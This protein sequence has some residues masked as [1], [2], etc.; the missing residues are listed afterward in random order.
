MN[1]ST[2]T[3]DPR[4]ARIHYDDY[5]KRCRL[6]REQRKKQAI[7]SE[8]HD[9][10]TGRVK[11][12]QLER[13]D[14]ELMKAYRALYRGQQILDMPKTI[15]KGGLNERKLPHLAICRADKV[16]CFFETWNNVIYMHH[17]R[18]RTWREH[19]LGCFKFRGG[20]F[21]AELT[22]TGWRSKNNF[23][24]AATA[25]VPSVPPHLRPDDLSKYFILWEA[26]WTKAAPIDPILLS[27]VNETFFAVVAQWDL[28]VLEQR[29]LEGRL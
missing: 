1:V 25:L 18:P 3:M 27:R 6:A 28:T 8:G 13:E 15:A 14:E 21:P 11:L 20:L 12:S 10:A 26:E 24:N 16:S 7:E 22:D 17:E 4:I 23:E 19:Q 5:R 9:E 2:I 29:V